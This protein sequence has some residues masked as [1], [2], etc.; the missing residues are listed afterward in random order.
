MSLESQT[1]TTAQEATETEARWDA[2]R[3][4]TVLANTVSE[5]IDALQGYRWTGDRRA[6]LLMLFDDLPGQVCVEE[7]E[8]RLECLPNLV[9]DLTATQWGV[10][11]ETICPEL[12]ERP[13]DSKKTSAAV[14]VVSWLLSS[15]AGMVIGLLIAA[16]SATAQIYFLRK[17]DQREER[18][19]QRRLATH[20]SLRGDFQNS[21]T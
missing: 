2:E 15:E 12:Y 8:D 5:R 11:C 10:V 9:D 3:A 14:S 17:L 1:E 6:A 4:Q 19:H 13:R 18:E 7:L 20:S 16:L 21:A